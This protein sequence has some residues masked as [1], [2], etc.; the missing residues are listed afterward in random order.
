MMAYIKFAVF[1]LVVVLTQKALGSSFD[2]SAGEFSNSAGE[3][4]PNLRGRRVVSHF[5]K[6]SQYTDLVSNPG[7]PVITSL[8]YCESS[9]LDQEATEADNYLLSPLVFTWSYHST[10]MFCSKCQPEACPE[11]PEKCPVG[12]VTDLCGCCTQGVCGVVEGEKCYNV[13]LEPALPAENKK[14]GLCGNN[15]HCLLRPDLSFRSTAPGASPSASLV[16]AGSIFYGQPLSE[17]CD[18]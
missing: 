6:K 2:V 11:T 17:E 15:L 10:L 9:E 1:L 18:H 16:S 14:Y 8:V 4:H 13:S 7:H 5:E 3:E 12:L